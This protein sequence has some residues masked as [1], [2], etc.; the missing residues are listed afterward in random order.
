MK[1]R[2]LPFLLALCL[3]FSGCAATP[4]I[5]KLLSPPRLTE[6]QSEIY[7]ALLNSAGKDIKL[8]YPKSGDYRSAFV[9]KNI[10]DEPTEE[11]IVFC[12]MSSV[13]ANENALRMNILDH[14]EKGWSVV[15]DL[16]GLGTDVEEVI[17][18][19]LG[20]GERLNL[21]VGYSMLNQT[22][23]TLSVVNYSDSKPT[24]LF[25]GSYSL[26]KV[27]DLDMDGTEELI[28]VTQDK[29]TLS[30][31]AGLY[32]VDSEGKFGKRGDAPMSSADYVN[33][34]FGFLADDVYAMVADYSKGVST[35]GTD[36]LYIVDGKLVNPINLVAEEERISRISNTYISVINSQDIDGDGFIEIPAHTPFPGYESLSRQEQFCATIWY[37]IS[38]HRLSEK[39]YS[40]FSAKNNYVLYFPSRWKGFVTAKINAEGNEISFFEVVQG[41]SVTTDELSEIMRIRT[42][43]KTAD[44]SGSDTDTSKLIVE[45]YREYK[46]NGEK[47]YYIWA[48]DW[49]SPLSLTESEL[50]ISFQLITGRDS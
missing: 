14:T 8:K 34:T 35:Y 1:K 46:T 39:Y 10:D 13:K 30:T 43:T 37:T 42:V 11:A 6:E 32:S 3:A 2:I 36:V 27:I 31:T 47:T 21:I 49:D 26:M 33:V 22:E 18:S 23:K 25:S 50:D 41:K 12:E 40:Y 19:T 17:F 48:S 7:A 38:N 44:E 15:F 4:G 45:G 16:P 28:T 5:E 9:M 29:A 20:N 24:E